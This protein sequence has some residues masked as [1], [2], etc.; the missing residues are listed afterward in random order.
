MAQLEKIIEENISLVTRVEHIQL[1]L[2]FMVWSF[3]ARCR[4]QII[5]ENNDAD[6]ATT[7]SRW[8]AV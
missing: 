1:S 3:L 4:G 2:P 6:E 5:P 7:S 8:M